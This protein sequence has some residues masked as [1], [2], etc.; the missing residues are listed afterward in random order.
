MPGN[1]TK[2]GQIV[3]KNDQMSV[4]ETT[5]CGANGTVD[6]K[7]NNAQEISASGEEEMA[8][9]SPNDNMNPVG[10]AAAMFCGLITAFLAAAIAI[11]AGFGFF[12]VVAVYIAVGSTFTLFAAFCATYVRF[13][14]RVSLKPLERQARD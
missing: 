7:S 6:P 8:T 3:I 2:N 5:D 12:G 10:A 9:S 13:E 11:Y 14:T 4:E 1:H